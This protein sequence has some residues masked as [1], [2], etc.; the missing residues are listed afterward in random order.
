MD[1]IGIAVVKQSFSTITSR[2]K[3]R[4]RIHRILIYSLAFG[5]RTVFGE[6]SALP[7]H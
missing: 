1:N 3:K 6:C 4:Q 7:K 5:F 2:L